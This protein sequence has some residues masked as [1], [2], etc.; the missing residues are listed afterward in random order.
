MTANKSQIASWGIA[1]LALLLVV[2]FHL[3][4]ALMG[5]LLVFE[6]VRILAGKLAVGKARLVAVVII[7]V[8]VI[9]VVS[10]VTVGLV[11]YFRSDAGSLPALLKEM[12]RIIDRSRSTL[13]P[14]LASNLPADADAIHSAAVLWLREHAAEVQML[15]KEAGRAAAY[16]LIGM[17]VGALLALQEVTHHSH[18]KPLAQALQERALRLAESFRRIVFAQVRIAALNA[19]FTAI[20]LAIALPLLGVHLPFTGS[21]ILFTFVAG[22]LPVVGNLLSNTVIVVVS[23]THSPGTALGSLVFLV[24][25]H[26]LEY[27]LNA[28]IVGGQIN[29][30]AWELLLAMLMMEAVF[31]LPGV[32]AAPV[33]YAYL[34]DELKGRGLV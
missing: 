11:A 33:Y 9:A 12:A 5:G 22:L 34:K 31:G 18:L 20:Y 4:P 24:V 19:L 26:K 29:A 1:A 8:L 6:L 14:W 21:M 27:F 10:I 2:Q 28:R 23:L 32:V 16:G 13:P 7:A 17:I 15:G 25:I 3:L 30:R